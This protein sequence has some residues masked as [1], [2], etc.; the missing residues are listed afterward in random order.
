MNRKALTE[1]LDRLTAQMSDILSKAETENRAFSDEERTQYEGLEAKAK[2][3]KATIK[4]I[5]DKNAQQ[6]TR[7]D[8]TDETQ[9]AAEERAFADF[10]R[11]TVENRTN[12]QNVGRT[13]GSKLIP[14]TIADRIIR[15]IKDRCP[16]FT[17]CDM[18][19]VAG[20]LQIPVYGPKTVSDTAHDIAAGYGAEFAQITAD[21][22]AFT[23]IDLK[24]YI[25]NAL[26][27]VGDDLIANAAFDV[28][29]YVVNLVADYMAQFI[30]GEM[31]TGSGD[32]NNHVTGACSTTNSL[33][34]A[35]TNKVT[36]D[37]LIELQMK[38][39]Q[40]WQADA[41]W[42]MNAATF[43]AVRKLKDGEG[44]YL[45]IPNLVDGGGFTLLGKPVY[46]SDNMAAMTTGNKPILYGAYGAMAAKLAAGIN[47]QVL[48]ERFSD[49]NAVGVIAKANFDCKPKDVR[50]LAVLT[51]A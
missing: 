7:T 33:T 38:V 14:T 8:E 46:L 23:S 28:V 30:E 3:V 20:T 26:V 50:G 4:A 37:E 9:Q 18:Y 51:M 27:L 40:N 43:T 19:Y 44:R 6:E 47:V 24:G 31:L 2:N 21:S 17:K 32:D 34:A 41:C 29:S 35:A 5:D 15:A 39:A 45:A 1:E 11:G 12:E 13:N 48:R 36:A 25:I 16:I 42:T 49:Q 22:G 10:I